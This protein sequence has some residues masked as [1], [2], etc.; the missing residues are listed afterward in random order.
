MIHITPSNGKLNL[1]ALPTSC[2]IELT[3][4]KIGN[5][6]KCSSLL[7]FAFVLAL[8]FVFGLKKDIVSPCK[9][10]VYLQSVFMC[11]GCSSQRSAWSP[12]SC[13]WNSTGISGI[14]TPVVPGRQLIVDPMSVHIVVSRCRPVFRIRDILVRIRILGFL[15]L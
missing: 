13:W 5:S 11:E 6:C 7:I 1:L 14:G 8:C 4:E 2:R 9:V 12:R 3:I 10:Q 15:P